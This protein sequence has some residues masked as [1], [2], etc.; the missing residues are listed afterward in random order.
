MHL[1]LGNLLGRTEVAQQKQWYRTE[2]LAN[3]AIIILLSLSH[4]FTMAAS[5]PKEESVEFYMGR[6]EQ[7]ETI[8][9]WV[10]DINSHLGLQGFFTRV[11]IFFYF[12]ANLSN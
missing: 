5:F 3:A 8:S 4:L 2:L 12:Y 10:F 6:K 9:G 1:A 11:V 7:R